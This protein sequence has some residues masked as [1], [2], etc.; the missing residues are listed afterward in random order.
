MESRYDYYGAGV[1]MMNEAIAEYRATFDS[2]PIGS[3]IE[4]RYHDALDT[5]DCA[6]LA[7][8]LRKAKADRIAWL[9]KQQGPSH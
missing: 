5:L 7:G 4:D 1:A 3:T 6:V 9:A 8:V 2:E